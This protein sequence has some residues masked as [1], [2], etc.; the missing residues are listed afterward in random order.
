MKKYLVLFLILMV[1]LSVVGCTNSGY[2]QQNAGT[3]QQ[4]NQ[5]TT[6]SSDEAKEIVLTVDNIYDY[7]TISLDIT[8]VEKKYLGAENSNADGKLTI[9]TSPRK[10]G[11]FNDVTLQITLNTSSSGWVADSKWE[12]REKT[13]IIP[14]DGK[15]EEIFTIRSNVIEDFITTSPRFEIT[16]NSVSGTFT[17]Q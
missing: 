16:I 17:K 1:L 2:A 7:L 3:N 8:D 10:R 13:L 14:F 5:T 12:S 15:F 4:N 11:D 9:K 6:T